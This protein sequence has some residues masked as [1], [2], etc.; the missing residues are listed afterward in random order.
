MCV[1]V[2]VCVCVCVHCTYYVHA[3][4]CASETRRVSKNVYLYK[5]KIDFV[6]GMPRTKSIFFPL[7]PLPPV[8]PLPPYP[9]PPC[10]GMPTMDRVVDE[11]SNDEDLLIKLR[12]QSINFTTGEFQRAVV[13]HPLQQQLRNES[14]L[15]RI[16][17]GD[18]APL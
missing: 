14:T 8:P 18:L 9:P 17:D 3:R 4:K 16:K 2:C 5:K 7:P 11:I 10:P 12:L 13:L 15:L 1:Y 6:P